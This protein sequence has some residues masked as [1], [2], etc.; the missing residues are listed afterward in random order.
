MLFRS[1]PERYSESVNLDLSDIHSLS[2]QAKDIGSWVNYKQ[3][4]VSLSDNINAKYSAGIVLAITTSL[5]K[6]GVENVKASYSS[7][8][9]RTRALRL[10]GKTKDGKSVIG[11]IMP[12]YLVGDEK[13]TFKLEKNK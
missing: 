7:D 5:R 11:L 6:L 1:V 10:D 9:S 13:A 3:V 8:E 2:K 12:M 4:T